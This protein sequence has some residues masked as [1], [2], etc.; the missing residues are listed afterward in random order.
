MRICQPKP[1]FATT[2]NSNFGW[3]DP[4]MR[5]GHP[6]PKLATPNSNLGWWNPYMRIGHPKPKFSN[7]S[8]P[9]LTRTWVGEI[10]I[11]GLA[12]PNPSFLNKIRHTK[13][14]LWLAKSVYE[15]W[16]PQTYVSK[17]SSPPETL[18][19][20][21]DICVFGLVIQNPS[22]QTQVRHPKL[23]LGMAESVFVGW[24]TQTQVRHPNLEL[25][26]AKFVY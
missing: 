7:P 18:P 10:R 4:Y 5:V 11:W 12:E 24:P 13:L 1:K 20:V 25:L 19:W 6:K 2:P 22:Y 16:P 26:L 21:G 23:E 8:S 9:P 15:G 14:E 17:P 3:R